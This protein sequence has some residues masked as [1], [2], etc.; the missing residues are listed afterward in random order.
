MT[1]AEN[2][3]INIWINEDRFDKLQQAGL[4]GLTEEVFAGLKRLQI[5]TNESQKD[6]LLKKYTM[7]KFDAATTKTIELLPKEA[8]DQIFDLVVENKSLAII[9]DFLGAS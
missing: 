7:A 3:P 2:F 1:Q 8:K 6:A 9:G 5:P 4:S